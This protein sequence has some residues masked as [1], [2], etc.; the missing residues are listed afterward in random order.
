MLQYIRQKIS[1]FLANTNYLSLQK[2]SMIHKSVKLKGV[3]LKGKIVIAEKARLS[4]VRMMGKV[5]VGRYTVINGPNTVIHTKIHP[6]EIGSFCSIAKD[7]SI[8][9][10][11]HDVS[12]IST[13]YF[14]S[15]IFQEDKIHEH[16]SRGPIK[17]GNDVW[18]GTKAVILSGVT[19]GNG[20]VIGANAVVT[21]D[22]PAYAIVGG[23]P[24]KVIKYRFEDDVIEALQKLAWW[25]WPLSKILENK[26]LFWNPLDRDSLNKISKNLL[27]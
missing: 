25:D 27:S 8:Q 16:I 13:Y 1:S 9:E 3:R 23:A 20:A 7:V 19:I 11:D 10:Y 5:S 22:V 26:S 17:I 6:V 21:R 4:G 24:A 14:R 2:G 12:R 15:N 18:I